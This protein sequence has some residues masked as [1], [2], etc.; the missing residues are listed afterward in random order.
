MFCQYMLADV[1]LIP[2]RSWSNVVSRVSLFSRSGGG[3]GGRDP[4]D[5]VGLG[6]ADM[7]KFQF[8]LSA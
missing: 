6:Q 2:N 3:G 5:E 4:G 1:S 8:D 7:P